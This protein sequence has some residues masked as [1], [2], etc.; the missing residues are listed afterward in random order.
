M[1]NRQTTTSEPATRRMTKID[2]VM[3]AFEDFAIGISLRAHAQ[4]AKRP[5]PPLVTEHVDRSRKAL[6]DAMT[7]FTRPM[8]RIINNEPNGVHHG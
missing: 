6:R 4:L 2:K 7:E 3:D 8:L 5:E 1:G